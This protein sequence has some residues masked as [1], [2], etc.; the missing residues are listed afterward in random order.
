M[1]DVLQLNPF[2]RSV[3][4]L[5]A[6]ELRRRARLV[7]AFSLLGFTGG[8]SLAASH[9]FF[10]RIAPWQCLPPLTAGLVA[11]SVPLLLLRRRM[12]RAAGHVIAACWLVACGWGVYLRG[13][14]ASPPV[15]CQV[16]MPFIA[17][18]LIDRRAAVQWFLIVCAELAA[19]PALGALGVVVPNRMPSE[20]FVLSNVV[21]AA[22]FGTLVLAMAFAL[23][24]L[25]E[26]AQ[27][28]LA[29]A[30]GQKLEAEREAQLL[31]ADRLASVG[32]LAASMAHEINN[33]LS[34]VIGN[35]EFL[36]A[37]A[38]EGEA[39]EAFRDALDG[40]ARVRTIVQDLKTFARADEEQ[41]AAVDLDRVVAS[42]LR[43]VAGQVRHRAAL[44]TELSEC[45][46][47][48]ASEVRLG[49]IVVNLVVNSAQAIP[50]DGRRDHEIV[51]AVRTD[52][53]GRAELSVRDTGAGIPADVLPRVTEPFF[54]TKPVG[55]GTGLGL[56]VCSNLVKRLGGELRIESVVG[57][58]TKVTIALPPATSAAES[59][60]AA[61][62]PSMTSGERLRFLL[63]DDDPAVLRAL[64]RMLRGHD[65]TLAH[66]GREALAIVERRR[67][68]DLVLC[69]VMMPE[70]TGV[71]VARALAERA[72]ELARRLIFITGGV[73]TERA[74]AFL[75]A[76]RHRVLQ[77][78]VE[79]SAL[80]SLC[81]ETARMP[82]AAV[83]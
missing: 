46:Q 32:Q 28:E 45:P 62:L 40:A 77:K 29:E 3:A 8:L 22:L 47:V 33:P 82:S 65:V 41:L 19:Y 75:G 18:V 49:Q 16:A 30:Q 6:P 12:L 57:Q 70:I 51:V 67:D 27:A 72:P 42:S 13:G 26:A 25:R 20:Y 48:L 83:G 56:A 54:T 60:G 68:F 39:R 79:L 15:M 78:P 17:I 5:F 61:E 35:L 7:A 80:R 14:L 64:D 36:A 1:A 53:K 23:E 66:G 71:E 50:D 2:D 9:F 11:G 44:R 63:I 52:E 4:R 38:P 10:F 34:Y 43:M 76:A 58:G 74:Q 81:R 21:A 69:D 31:R 73:T 37:S 55:V 59:A 24:W